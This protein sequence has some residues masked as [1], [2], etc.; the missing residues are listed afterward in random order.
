MGDVSEFEYVDL[1]ASLLTILTDP[2]QYSN[3]CSH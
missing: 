1:S 3:S 2:V